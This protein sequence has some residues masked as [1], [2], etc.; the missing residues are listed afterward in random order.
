M[1]M[2]QTN[3]YSIMILEKK[4]NENIAQNFSILNWTE[5]CDELCMMFDA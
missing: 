2:M 1:K 5:A 4:K 3:N